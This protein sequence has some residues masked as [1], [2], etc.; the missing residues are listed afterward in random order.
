MLE[1]IFPYL[2]GTVC[3]VVAVLV[4]IVAFVHHRRAAET[5]AALAANLPDACRWADLQARVADKERE[6]ESIRA[7][8]A[9]AQAT[10]AQKEEAAEW[11]R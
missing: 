6:F 8:L 2:I 11:L 1:L 7:E 9:Q 10:I 4:A 3:T 5:Y